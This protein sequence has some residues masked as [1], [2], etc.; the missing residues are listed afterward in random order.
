MESQITLARNGNG[1]YGPDKWYVI[2]TQPQADHLAALE[3]R[4]AGYEI[5]SPTVKDLHP[6]KGNDHTPLFP[7]YIFLHWNL[8]GRGRPSFQAAPHVAG[9]VSFDGEV[10]CVPDEVVADLAHRVESINS[11]GGLWRRF[12]CGEKVRVVSRVVQTLAEVVEE[13]RSPQS[14]V[15][16]LMEFMGRL[17]S[18]QVPWEN[19]QPVESTVGNGHSPSSRRTRGR[20]RW[21]RGFGPQLAGD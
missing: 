15:K 6:K 17:V 19:L 13:P 4:Q 14:R 8:E 11:H 7:G 10:P 21:I 20:G 1:K 5:F 16:V 3:L 18:A 9:W 2:R 12:K